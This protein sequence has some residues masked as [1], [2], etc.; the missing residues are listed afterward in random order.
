MVRGLE[1]CD[2]HAEIQ[3]TFQSSHLPMSWSSSSSACSAT[4]NISLSVFASA[5]VSFITLVIMSGEQFAGSDNHSGPRHQS[6][7]VWFTS[8]PRLPR[9]SGFFSVP[10]CLHSMYSSSWILRARLP[11]K[12]LYSPLPQIQWSATVLS[13]QQYLFLI[14][15]PC[16]AFLTLWTRLVAMCPD[17]SSIPPPGL[18]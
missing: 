17:T 7:D 12:C 6:L 2:T 16:K 4:A 1:I 10:T 13:N 3:I 9:S 14:E 11:T 18:G 8:L 5:F 15:N